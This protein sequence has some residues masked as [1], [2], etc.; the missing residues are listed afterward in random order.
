MEGDGL[1]A[2]PHSMRYHG[3]SGTHKQGSSSV[4]RTKRFFEDHLAEASLDLIAGASL[5]LR[6]SQKKSH[7]IGTSAIRVDLVRT[8]QVTSTAPSQKH[9]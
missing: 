6:E 4:G 2:A 8:K 1:K 5:C 3:S 7:L 9:D